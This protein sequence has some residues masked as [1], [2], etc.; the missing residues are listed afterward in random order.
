MGEGILVRVLMGEHISVEVWGGGG[1]DGEQE[2]ERQ[3]KNSKTCKHA[4]VKNEQTDRE[5]DVWM[6]R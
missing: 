4:S 3:R 5:I 1:R 6:V 2:K